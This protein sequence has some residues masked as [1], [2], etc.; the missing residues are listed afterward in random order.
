[1]KVRFD[2]IL[3]LDDAD[4]SDMGETEWTSQRTREGRAELMGIP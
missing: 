1:M 2:V 4:A 3:N